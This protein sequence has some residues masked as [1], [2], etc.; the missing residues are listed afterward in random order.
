MQR[1]QAERNAAECDSWLSERCCANEALQGG[2][3]RFQAERNAA[4]ALAEQKQAAQVEPF[5]AECSAF[6]QSGMQL[7]A[8][9][10]LLHKSNRLRM[11]AVAVPRKAKPS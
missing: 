7:N 2:V 4:G 9:A 3:Q 10:G 8:N 6:R 11:R 1:F 5:K